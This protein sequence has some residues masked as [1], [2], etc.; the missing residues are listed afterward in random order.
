MAAIAIF[1]GAVYGQGRSDGARKVQQAWDREK[2][3]IAQQHVAAITEARE[4]ENALQARID[5]E[6]R[7]Y[8]EQISRVNAEYSSLLAGLRQRPEVRTNSCPAMPENS[9]AAV[10]C[11]GAGLARPD[12]EFLA[13]YAADAARLEIRFE[14]CRAAYEAVR[15]SR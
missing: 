1:V 3:T 10:G 12:A 14:Q 8:R 4:R 6:R 11:T 5:L 9:G 2:A 13:G 7:N 15:V